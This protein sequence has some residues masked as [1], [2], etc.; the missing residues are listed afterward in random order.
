MKQL[1]FSGTF[2]QNSINRGASRTAAA[3]KMELFAVAKHY[4]EHATP[5]LVFEGYCFAITF[6]FLLIQQLT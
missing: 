6:S 4:Q 5:L 1:T 2:L 3:S